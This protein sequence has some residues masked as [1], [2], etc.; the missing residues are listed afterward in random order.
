ML[1]VNAGGLTQHMQAAH[2]AAKRHAQKSSSPGPMD[3]EQTLFGEDME[4]IEGAR[5]QRGAFTIFHP[6]IDG[7]SF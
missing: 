5:Q 2:S 6:L 3:H 1:V 4:E 7:S